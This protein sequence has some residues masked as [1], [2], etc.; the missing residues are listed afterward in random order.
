LIWALPE[1]LA[2]MAGDLAVLSLYVV[3]D[4]RNWSA[5]RVMTALAGVVQGRQ[6]AADPEH[7]KR[8]NDQ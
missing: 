1:K 5:P 4:V 7:N 2:Y 6:C 3:P 8:Q